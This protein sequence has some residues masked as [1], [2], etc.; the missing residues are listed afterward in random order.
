[1][2]STA[3]NLEAIQNALD[4]HKASCGSPVVEIRMN[5]YEVERLGFDHFAGIPIVD[6]ESL[7]TGRLRLVCEGDHSVEPVPPLAA[8]V[9][10]PLQVEAPQT[11]QPLTA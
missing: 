9:E 1:M 7:G 3:K 10:S 2:N 4:Q 6:D 11:P 8:D 5:P